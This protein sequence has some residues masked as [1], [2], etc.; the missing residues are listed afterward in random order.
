GG[1]TMTRRTGA[2]H[3]IYNLMTGVMA[4]LLLPVASALF[5]RGTADPQIALVAFHS[6]F[7]I[8]GVVLVLPFTTPFARLIERIVPASGA[9]LTR[10]LDSAALAVPA[11]AVRAAADT[12]EVMARTLARHVAAG[13]GN[14]AA[15]RADRGWRS[16]DFDTALLETRSYLRE[17]HARDLTAAE[18]D[19]D[20]ASFHVLDHLRR[21]QFR[22]G[23][24]GRLKVIRET[25]ELQ[26]H[27]EDLARLSQALAENGASEA[28][29]QEFDA[30]RRRL[31]EERRNLRGT[32]VEQA[33]SG[34][35]GHDEAAARMDALR[36]LHRSGY[37]LWRIALHLAETRSDETPDTLPEPPPADEAAGPV[38]S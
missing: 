36:W 22:C 9:A 12:V 8:L 38:Q 30:F 29:T 5:L 1:S 14:A 21:L 35:I 34:H 13:L 6:A 7:N 16:D 37:H 26:P 32:L 18:I 28:M 20:E 24:I 2:A 11:L 4:F 15:A 17:I 23:Q 19:L 3:V 33:A 31:R 27:G 25:R 10:R